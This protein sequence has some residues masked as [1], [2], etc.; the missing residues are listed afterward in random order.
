MF[1]ECYTLGL[2]RTCT[3][4]KWNNDCSKY[5]FLVLSTR[6]TISSI[7]I[8]KFYCLKRRASVSRL[9]SK[10]ISISWFLLNETSKF[11]TLV[12]FQSSQ[13]EFYRRF[14]LRTR[15]I[16]WKWPVK[17]LYLLV[18]AFKYRIALDT[19]TWYVTNMSTCYIRELIGQECTLSHL[20]LRDI[21]VYCC[22]WLD[23]LDYDA[24]TSWNSRNPVASYS[25][26]AGKGLVDWVTNP[27]SLVLSS[28]VISPR[29][30]GILEYYHPCL[31]RILGPVGGLNG[32]RRVV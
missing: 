8:T 3:L 30:I 20:P 14:G 24:R 22:N 7:N 21:L 23:I 6:K 26:R 12:M 2:G 9:L 19:W 17:A 16:T 1:L 5:V 15:S 4:E 29:L 18:S 10:W 11:R 13:T 27:G 32:G 28:G 31:L 25:S